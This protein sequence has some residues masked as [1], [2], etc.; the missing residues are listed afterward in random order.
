MKRVLVNGQPQYDIQVK[1]QTYRTKQTLSDFGADAMIG[2]GTRVFEVY[3]KNDSQR[4]S[5]ALKDTWVEEDGPREGDILRDFFSK[6]K[7]ESGEDELEK[8]RQYFLN[9]VTHGDITINNQRDHIKDLI[10]RGQD[11]PEGRSV[12]LT[13]TRQKT[14]HH[15][16]TLQISSVGHP[17]GL[18]DLPNRTVRPPASPISFRVHYRIVF[19]GV[20]LAVHYVKNLRTVYQVLC[21]AVE[22]KFMHSSHL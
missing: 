22:G 19:E 13:V 16:E 14:S 1:E 8:A 9:I 7:K 21:D 11:L 15:S 17:P 2:R 3:N 18:E 4:T 6:I 10:M 5:L 20:G 12:S